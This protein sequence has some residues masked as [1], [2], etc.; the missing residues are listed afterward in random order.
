MPSDAFETLKEIYQPRSE[1]RTA[2]YAC[3]DRGQRLV[4]GPPV[5]YIY[6]PVKVPKFCVPVR[7]T[8]LQTCRNMAAVQWNMHRGDPVGRDKQCTANS[9]QPSLPA[10]RAPNGRTHRL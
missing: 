10:G 7:V 4:G 3:L 9:T 1:P 5:Y 8:V 2:Q 6:A